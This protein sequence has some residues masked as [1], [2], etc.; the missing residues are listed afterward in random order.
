MNNANQERPINASD[1]IKDNFEPRDRIALLILNRET[2]ESVQRITTAEKASSPEFQAWLRHRNATGDEIYVGMNALKQ[3]AAT[4]T[5]D[6]VSTIRH[7]YNRPRPWRGRSNCANAELR[8]RSATELRARYIAGPLSNRLE[9][10]RDWT[11]RGGIFAT[12]N[13]P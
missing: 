6:Q 12:S 4:R 1:Y 8:P 3:D 9:G 2:G 11:S 7:L 10:R 13:D 5:K